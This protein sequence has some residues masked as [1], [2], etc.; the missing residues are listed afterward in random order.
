[1]KYWLI[2]YC[3]ILLMIC[4]NALV[5]ASPDAPAATLGRLFFS[6][7]QRAKL[8]QLRTAPATQALAVTPIAISVQGYIQRNGGKSSTVWLN[9]QAL[10][11]HTTH[12]GVQIGKI[13]AQGVNLQTASRHI[14][15]K[16]GQSY[17]SPEQDKP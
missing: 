4:P 1:M 15:L 13:E 6:A 8:D 3:L 2:K 5:L 11:E 17:T 7:P 10:P 9:H 14:Y 12:N 16:A